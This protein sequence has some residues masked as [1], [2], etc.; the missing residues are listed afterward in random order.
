MTIERME[1]KLPFKKLKE[2][3]HLPSLENM[4]KRLEQPP[5]E[6]VLEQVALNTITARIPEIETKVAKLMQEKAAKKRADKALINARA[7][8][9]KNNCFSL[10]EQ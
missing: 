1:L 2:M 6:N 4:K 7:K 10:E 9:V 3:K 5:P 8:K